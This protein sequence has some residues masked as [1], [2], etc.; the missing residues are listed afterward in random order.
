MPFCR[1]LS[2]FLA[3]HR[4]RSVLSTSRCLL[5]ICFNSSPPS[6]AP[7]LHSLVRF[8]SLRRLPPLARL[9]RLR[10]PT[11]P[12]HL[13][14]GPFAPVAPLKGAA[15]SIFF[16]LLFST[17]S[18]YRPHLFP[19]RVFSRGMFF[20]SCLIRSFLRFSSPFLLSPRTFSPGIGLWFS[21]PRPPLSPVRSAE[22]PLPRDPTARATPR[23]LSPSG[24]SR[25]SFFF[26][27]SPPP[28]TQTRRLKRNPPH[29]HSA[30]APFARLAP[31]LP[32]PLISLPT[33]SAPPCAF[34][35]LW[36]LL[37]YLTLEPISRACLK[38]H[39]AHPRRPT[40][41]RRRQ[42][43]AARAVHTP[44]KA[45][46]ARARARE[47]GRPACRSNAWTRPRAFAEDACRASGS[48]K[49]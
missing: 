4:R 25:P 8:S 5:P 22:R 39:I 46:P 28:T 43:D 42:T 10:A 9:V 35:L 36:L 6:S 17:S 21:F 29:S 19:L 1:P 49:S 12:L 37:L 47:C 41:G 40:S 45:P 14:P 18:G 44:C 31:P 38:R 23:S 15:R 2:A 34:V 48:Q 20:L 11:S 7:V 32:L 24:L 13:S 26:V 16:F 33:T 3:S 27:T 30:R